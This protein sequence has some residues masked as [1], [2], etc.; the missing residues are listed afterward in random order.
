MFLWR[1]VINLNPFT[2]K[3]GSTQRSGMGE[4]VAQILNECIVRRFSVDKR[5]VRDHMGILVNKQKRKVRAEEKASGIA[6]D[7]QSELENLLD[8]IIAVEEISEAES[9]ELGVE[10]NEKCE[11]D[12][13]KA[14]DARLKAMK[15]LSET[16]KRSSESEE[17]KPKRQRSYAMEFLTDRAKMNYELKQQEFKMLQEQQALEREKMEA[18]AKQ[19]LQTQQQQTEMFEVIQQQQQQQSQQQP[20]NT[21]MMMMQQQ[22]EQTR[23]MMALLEKLTNK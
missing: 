8:T 12:R 10:K 13:A 7:E 21:Q 2:S 23:A 1:E 15:K 6:P 18:M 16:R 5:S 3:K 11:N 17:E 20:V 9:Q 14:E 4:K 19:Q 22:Q